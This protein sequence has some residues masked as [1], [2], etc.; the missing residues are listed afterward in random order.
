MQSANIKYG[1]DNVVR[2]LPYIT[3]TVGAGWGSPKSRHKEQGCVN[4]VC[5]KGDGVKKSEH[6]ANADVIYGS[7]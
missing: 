6:F 1:V 3:S 7:P 4:Y 5:D 2:G